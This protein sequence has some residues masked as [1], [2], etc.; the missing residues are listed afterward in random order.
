MGSVGT[1]TPATF[2]GSSAFSAQ[3]QQVIATAVANASAPITQLQNEQTSL[4]NQQTEL[5]TLSSEFQSLQTSLDSI[6]SA[7]G[8][9][10]LSATV[11]NTSVASASLSTGAMAGT[12]S[13][14]VVSVG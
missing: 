7:T 8:L 2:T 12:Y 14:N 5:Q 1:T 6:N 9:G 10:A 4:S 11:D 13:V 3:L